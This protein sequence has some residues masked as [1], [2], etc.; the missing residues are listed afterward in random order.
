MLLLLIL[1]PTR[2][3]HPAVQEPSRGVLEAGPF[4]VHP[5]P[6]GARGGALIMQVRARMTACRH[7]HPPP[8]HLLHSSFPHTHAVP[9]Q[10]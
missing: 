9:S 8:L 1:H 5:H 6:N 2:S 7:A 10:T 3:P 4:E